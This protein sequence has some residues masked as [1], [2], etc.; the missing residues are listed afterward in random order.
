MA[1]GKFYAAIDRNLI[2]KGSRPYNVCRFIEMVVKS[3]APSEMMTY[4]LDKE[5][6]K[7][8][9]MQTKIGLVLSK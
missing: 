1:I 2:E 5:I 4:G 9:H 3:S 7:V 6:T 8:K